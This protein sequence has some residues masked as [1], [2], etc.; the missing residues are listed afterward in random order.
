[1]VCEHTILI[2][3]VAPLVYVNKSPS[4]KLAPLLGLVLFVIAITGFLVKLNM[5]VSGLKT[6]VA[7]LKTEVAVLKTEV[8][9]LKEEDLRLWNQTWHY[10]AGV[11]ATGNQH[12]ID[13]FHEVDNLI[14]SRTEL[15]P[16]DRSHPRAT[17]RDGAGGVHVSE[18]TRLS[19][20]GSV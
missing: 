15:N 3:P 2:E 9:G 4:N 7:G 1:M 11:A 13:L 8:A 20:H 14:S 10:A 6:E 12:Y 19:S 17:W 5:D 18:A 16:I